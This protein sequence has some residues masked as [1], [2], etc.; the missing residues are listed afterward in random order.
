MPKKVNYIWLILLGA[1]LITVLANLGLLNRYLKLSQIQELS[2]ARAEEYWF[3]WRIGFVGVLSELIILIVFIFYNYTWKDY[4]ISTKFHRTKRLTLIFVSNLILLIGFIY[5]DFLIG[6]YFTKVI[7]APIVVANYLQN[8]FINHT[9]VLLIAIIAPYILLRVEKV[10]TMELNL[11]KIKEEKTR[12]ELSTL[13]EQISPHFFFNTLSTLS[14]IVRNESKEA[15]LEFI[16]DI[17]DTYRYTLTEAKADLVLLSQEINFISSYV[18]LLQRRFGEK[19]QFE[20]KIRDADRN[21]SIP[22]MSIQLLIENAIKHNVMTKDLPLK[23]SICTKDKMIHVVNN[24]QEK[25]QIESFG[26]GLNNLNNRYK[27]LANQ[28]IVIERDLSTFTVQL[29][30]L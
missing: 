26:L 25:E 17:S 1:I 15:S 2:E 5:L 4:F 21:S 24:L 28:E 14:T 8:Y 10:K 30:L 3:I 19:L 20:M 18:Y 9:S 13:R 12:A 27:L 22:S 23:I 7:S 29:P 6:K 11:V 16:Q